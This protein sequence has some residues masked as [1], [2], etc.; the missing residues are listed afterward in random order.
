MPS[1]AI[2]LLTELCSIPTAPFKEHFVLNWIDNFAKQNK[3]KVTKDSFG[4]RLLSVGPASGARLIFV[5]HADHP[6]LVANEMIDAKAL[7]ATFHGGVLSDFVIGEKVKF[8][9]GKRGENEIRGKISQVTKKAEWGDYPIEV[10][11]NVKSPVLAGTPGMFDQ[12]AGRVR[13]GRFYSRVC[14]DLAGV[15]A[16]LAAMQQLSRKKLRA[17]VCTLI[18][19]AEEIGFIGAMAAVKSKELLRKTDRLI[20]VE[21]SAEQPY[22]LQGNGVILRVG[23][24]TSIFNSA[25]TY[26]INMQCEELAKTDK[27]FKYQR[28]LMP[29]GSCEGTVFDS[30]GYLAA[31]A[32]VPLGNYHNMDRA[33]KKIGPEF[34]DLRD[35]ENEVKLFTRL[36]EEAHDVDLKF[37][38]LKKR[39]E[40]R[41][42]LFGKLLRD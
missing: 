29:G 28:C 40:T 9:A 24:R 38:A 14:D 4:N 20:S 31:A 2:K 7:R 27:T 18:T 19:R 34:V 17:P 5:A 13:G 3:I 35:W 23:D 25:F 26:W 16:I 39:L 37:G 1:A 42:K 12:G 11:V 33:N 32:C 10:L 21:C 22:A 8:F 30:H 6:G 36:G 41:Y 15:A